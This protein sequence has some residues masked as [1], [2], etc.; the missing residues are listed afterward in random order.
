MGGLLLLRAYGIWDFM[1]IFRDFMEFF[2]ILSGKC[3]RDFLEMIQP[4]VRHL[5]LI[6]PISGPNSSTFSRY[7]EF[8]SRILS[9]TGAISMVKAPRLIHIENLKLFF[10]FCIGLY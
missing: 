4:S 2:M 7:T 5:C 6:T 8:E 3:V 9:G 1:G 10:L